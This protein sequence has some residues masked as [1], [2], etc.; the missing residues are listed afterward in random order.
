MAQ[1]HSKPYSKHG[2]RHG[3][4]LRNRDGGDSLRIPSVVGGSTALSLGSP[5]LRGKIQLPDEKNTNL[6]TGEANLGEDHSPFF[7]CP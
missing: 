7:R 2:G 6:S 1:P 4:A 5:S 3:T